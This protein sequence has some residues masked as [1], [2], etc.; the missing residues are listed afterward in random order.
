MSLP[1]GMNGALPGTNVLEAFE[2]YLD[3]KLTDEFESCRGTTLL[4]TKANVG[5]KIAGMKIS[6]GRQ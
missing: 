6:S 4:S 5:N 1:D 3:D 2:Y